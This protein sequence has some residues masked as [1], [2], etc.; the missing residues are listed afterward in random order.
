VDRDVE[1]HVST[2]PRELARDFRSGIQKELLV[3]LGYA[4][5]ELR[6]I[7]STKTPLSV[8][9]PARVR[10]ARY[11]GDYDTDHAERP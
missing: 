5:A 1:G 7:R 6:P 2:A 3:D 4:T 10:A 8:P 11:A 9:K